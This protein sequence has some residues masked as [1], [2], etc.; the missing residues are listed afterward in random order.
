MMRAVRSSRKW[1]ASS[2]AREYF[3]DGQQHVIRFQR[4]PQVP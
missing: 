1:L 4:W 3:V 2:S